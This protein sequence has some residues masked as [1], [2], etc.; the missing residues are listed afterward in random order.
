MFAPT[1]Q[2]AIPLLSAGFAAGALIGAAAVAGYLSI[3]EPAPADAAVEGRPGSETSTSSLAIGAG[4]KIDAAGPD[5]AVEPDTSDEG[6]TA[7]VSPQEMRNLELRIKDLAIRLASVEQALNALPSASPAAS[8]A[9]ASRPAAPRTPAERS[10]ALVSVGV[11]PVLAEDLVLREAERSLEQLSLRDQAIREGW[12]GTEQ[13]REE[14]ARINAGATSLMDEI[15]VDTYDLYLYATGEDNR[16][17]V[18][19]VIPGSAAE[20]AGLQSGDL[21]ESADERLFRFSDLR[22]KTTEG[23]YGEQVALRVRRGGGLVETW[24][25]R[26]PL[27][28][29]LDSARVSLLLCPAA[30][31]VN[32]I[33]A[34]E[35]AAAGRV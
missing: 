7:S 35:P 16:V 18:T 6:K 29:T 8:A 5:P 12:I 17:Q 30:D 10:A 2:P 14:L 20:V 31:P 15:G 11:D 21:I 34:P 24:V 26:G 4:T 28:V 25:P 27:G 3:S 32:D 9:D 33:S 23:E 22:S 19:S 13:Y 1:M